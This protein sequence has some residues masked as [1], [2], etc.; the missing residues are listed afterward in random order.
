MQDIKKIQMILN[1][2]NFDRYLE[3]NTKGGMIYIHNFHR[4][5]YLRMYGSIF[6]SL[7]HIQLDT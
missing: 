6:N 2:M 4:K 5:C 1:Q 7:P 3:V